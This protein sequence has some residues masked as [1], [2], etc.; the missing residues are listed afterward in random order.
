MVAQTM[1]SYF[2]QGTAFSYFWKRRDWNIHD[3]V[4]ISNHACLAPLSYGVPAVFLL[5]V[6][7]E[8]LISII[9][10][11]HIAFPLCHEKIVLQ[12]YQKCI[13]SCPLHVHQFYLLKIK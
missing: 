1:K 12:F 8:I 9:L 2:N 7:L 3:R 11:Y 10:N 13:P 5:K 4:A 6:V